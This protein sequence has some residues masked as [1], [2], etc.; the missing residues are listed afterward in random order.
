[1]R[2]L[3]RPLHLSNLCD[4]AIG[5]DM[6]VRRIHWITNAQREQAS[7][8]HQDT[9]ALRGWLDVVK[10]HVNNMHEALHHLL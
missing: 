8:L 10:S 1:M 7:D 4:S 9:V 6:V 2:Y 3:D 5:W